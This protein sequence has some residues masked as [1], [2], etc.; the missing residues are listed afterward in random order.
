MGLCRNHTTANFATLLLAVACGS[1]AT[2][3]PKQ[4]GKHTPEPLLNSATATNFGGGGHQP[5][6]TTKFV[7]RGGFKIP[8]ELTPM[9]SVDSFGAAAAAA[10]SMRGEF[11]GATSNGNPDATAA[12]GRDSRETSHRDRGSRR[13]VEH[14]LTLRLEGI[15]SSTRMKVGSSSE[16]EGAEGRAREAGGRDGPRRSR[17]RTAGATVGRRDPSSS[18]GARAGAPQT[19][20]QCVTIHSLY[21]L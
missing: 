9:S 3:T 1:P 15:M 20:Q 7:Y 2:W 6:N 8:K 21:R 13:G 17:P 10:A 4:D 19:K 18:A 14:D 11:G 5:Q 16:R 12:V